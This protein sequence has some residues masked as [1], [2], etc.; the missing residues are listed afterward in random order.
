MN[1]KQRR[2]V[3]RGDRLVV[4]GLLYVEDD[5]QGKSEAVMEMRDLG[6]D[7]ENTV[8][9]SVPG[10]ME[11]VMGARIFAEGN[12]VDGILVLS[13]IDPNSNSALATTVVQGLNMISIDWNIP[14]IMSSAYGTK[15]QALISLIQMINLQ[16]DLS[17]EMLQVPMPTP[18]NDYPCS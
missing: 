15:L 11:L 1:I 14:I 16:C 13:N 18:N 7:E 12:N 2:E 9:R 10:E 5:K 6:F 17:P 8:I 4:I 3:E